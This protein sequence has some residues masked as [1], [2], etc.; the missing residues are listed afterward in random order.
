MALGDYET[1]NI[2]VYLENDIDEIS[3]SEMCGGQGYLEIKDQP[4]F[5]TLFGEVTIDEPYQHNTESASD[6]GH[7]PLL[8]YIKNSGGSLGLVEI[9][10]TIICDTIECQL[11]YFYDEEKNLPKFEQKL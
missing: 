7:Y 5:I 10:L 6:V 8:I 4:E 9:D 2:P 1:V 3:W 11:N